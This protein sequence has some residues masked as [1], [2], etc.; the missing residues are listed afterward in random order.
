MLYPWMVNHAFVTNL[1]AYGLEP[2]LWFCPVRPSIWRQ[3]QEHFRSVSGGKEIATVAD[4][5]Q[6]FIAASRD[7]AVLPY[8]WWVPRPVEGFDLPYPS[9][10]EGISRTQ[11]GW[12]TRLDDPSVSVQP[13]LS[14]AFWATWD[15]DRKHVD[16]TSYGGMGHRL[17][18]F[19]SVLN[20]NVTFADGRVETRPRA[21]LQWQLNA[22]SG[23]G[24]FVY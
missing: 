14:D 16:Y 12:P 11:V 5:S 7:Y 10:G 17:S 19:Q 23:N 9:P 2:P 4:L 1:G 21:K 22:G 6:A 15:E 8:A 13:I 3:H 18:I 20:L 24:T